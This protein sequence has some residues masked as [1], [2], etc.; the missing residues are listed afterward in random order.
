MRRARARPCMSSCRSKAH[1]QRVCSLR[2]VSERRVSAPTPPYRRE[3]RRCA[4]VAGAPG[5]NLDRLEIAFN[6][7]PEVTKG[8]GSVNRWKVTGLTAFLDVLPDQCPA[9]AEAQPPAGLV[10]DGHAV[11]L[12]VSA[13]E[14]G[15]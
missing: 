3:V 1:W 14:L 5:Q 15:E 9:R 8:G 6:H 7:C 12:L 11:V 10:V 4:A 2:R 13:I